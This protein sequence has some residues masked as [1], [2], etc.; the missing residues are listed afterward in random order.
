MAQP[1]TEPAR[2]ASAPPPQHPDAA[3]AAGGP[4]QAAEAATGLDMLLVDAA[5]GPLRRLVP[6]AGTA[7]RFGSALARKPDV[8][9]RRGGE[10][11]RELG[12]VVA[13]R[14]ELAPGK[15]DKRFTDPAWSG[16]PL[17]K[18][19]MQAHLAAARVAWELI[20]DADLDWQDDERIRFTATNLVDALAPSNVPVV[21][22][23]SLKA[24]IDTGGA[25]AFKGL[26]R[27]VKD[28]A[29]PPRVPTMVEPDAFTV[30]EDLAVT[31]GA[32]VFR[33]DV[34]ELIQYRPT[35]ETVRA[36]PLVMVPPTINKFYIA[37]M[38]PGRSIVEHY[39][40]S[41]QQVFM[42]SWR[43]PDERHADWDLDTYGQAVLDAMDA[44]ERITGQEQVALQAFCSGGIITAMVL[45]HLA[46]TGRQDRVRAVSYAV[47]VLDWDRAGTMSALMDEEAVQAATERSRK[48]GYLDGAQLAEVF[49]WLRPNDLV[50]NYWVN[51]YLQGKPP[52][53]FDILF[54]NADT[55]RMTAGLHRGFI[56]VALK[57]AL[58]RPGASRMLGSPVDLSAVTVDSYVTAGIADHI[59]PWQSCYRSTQ[60]LGGE[61]RF[62]L[63][64]NGHIASLVNPPGN[65]KS[66]FQVAESTPPDPDRWLQQA[67]TVKGSW[68]PDFMSWLGN[69]SGEEIPAPRELGGNG[70]EVLA[71][72]PGTYVFDK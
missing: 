24:V 58:T 44:V 59:C 7:L 68:W 22:P 16:N 30:G 18:R 67:E 49:A 57:N 40:S 41:G 10:L 31:P 20:E 25:S 2:T 23:L 5:R 28:L 61:S 14:S 27:M 17:L 42:M 69:R 12:K 38:A 1:T 29:N 33:T 19:A 51:N 3:P 47:T 55:T 48:K 70:L 11:A 4:E 34:F 15:K 64:T 35:T 21:N 46:A 66:T 52:P 63:S 37:D 72:A 62:I 6:P 32:V 50:W 60:L 8:V 54:W 53:N 36:L 26:R 71:E 65:P 13:G 9:A 39:V 43:N 45:A 56:E